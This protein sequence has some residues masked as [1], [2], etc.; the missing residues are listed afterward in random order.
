[1]YRN[2]LVGVVIVLSVVLGATLVGRALDREL[3]QRVQFTSDGQTF[4]CERRVN[5]QG[6]VFYENCARVP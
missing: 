2:F 1:M 3:T 5:E 4:D 6:H